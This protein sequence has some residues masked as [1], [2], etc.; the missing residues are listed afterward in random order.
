VGQPVAPLLPQEALQRYFDLL[1]E[2][3]STVL[4][5]QSD[6]AELKGAEESVLEGDLS[7][8]HIQEA[9]RHTD[10]PV[11]TERRQ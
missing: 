8:D 3:A 5:L 2:E 11:N 6:T 10:I 1:S 9:E 7:L 4:T